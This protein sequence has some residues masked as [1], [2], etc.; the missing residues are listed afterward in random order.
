M[1]RWW[2]TWGG[3]VWHRAEGLNKEQDLKI[4]APIS[5]LRQSE[6]A[7]DEFAALER[8]RGMKKRA[9]SLPTPPPPPASSSFSSSSHF[10]LRTGPLNCHLVPVRQ[11][12][13]NEL[14]LM[15]D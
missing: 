9:Q 2:G 4:A 8:K 14:R 12:K 10:F 5:L 6:Q 1:A 13:G 15:A 3:G 11:Q 7:Q